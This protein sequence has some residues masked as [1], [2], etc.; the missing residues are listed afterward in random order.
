MLRFMVESFQDPP[1][2]SSTESVRQIIAH[3]DLNRPFL[4]KKGQRRLVQFQLFS[5]P[6]PN[7]SA[8]RG[9]KQDSGNM[10]CQVVTTQQK[11]STFPYRY[12]LHILLSLLK[13]TEGFK[14]CCSTVTKTEIPYPFDEF[15]KQYISFPEQRRSQCDG[16]AS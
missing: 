9:E 12:S 1:L 14:L 10:A 6:L 16:Y 11:I 3:L 5:L 7:A 8:G 13:L 2:C 15:Q 4:L